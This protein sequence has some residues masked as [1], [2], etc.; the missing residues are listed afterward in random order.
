MICH[1]GGSLTAF[2]YRRFV[3]P[4]LTESIKAHAGMDIIGMY[5]RKFHFFRHILLI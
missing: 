3:N 5:L 4:V 1:F 2:A